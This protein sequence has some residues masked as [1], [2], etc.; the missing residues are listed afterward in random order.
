MMP[1][2]TTNSALATMAA[3]AAAVMIASCGGGSDGAGAAATTPERRLPL[4]AEERRLEERRLV[5]SRDL[6]EA[7]RGSVQRAFY[8]YWSALENEEWSVALDYFPSETQR[9]LKRDTLVAALRVEAQ[10]PL[11]K[12]LIRGVRPARADQTS[13]RFFVRRSTGEL[14]P[15][16][17]S[18][19]LRGGRWYIAYSSTLDD[20]YSTAVQQEV[21]ANSAPGS[22]RVS[23]RARQ[24]GVRALRAQAAALQP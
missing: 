13:V 16:S 3:F 22:S 11:V 9:R 23:D 18:W 19:R 14:R 7:R 8:D 15:T 1:Y 21:Q 20:S 10:T 17:M 12:P 2:L 5:S 6:R 24:A 4:E